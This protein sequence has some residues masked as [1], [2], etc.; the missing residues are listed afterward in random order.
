MPDT[1]LNTPGVG[2][3]SWGMSTVLLKYVL[4][5]LL[6]QNLRHDAAHGLI[7][8]ENASKMYSVCS[9]GWFRIK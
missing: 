4:I 5:H 2:G 8:R 6:G 1:F 7:N 9:F 3:T